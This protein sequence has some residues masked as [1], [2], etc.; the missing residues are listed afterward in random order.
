[1]SG[2][3]YAVILAGFLTVSIAY[4]IR[5]GYGMLLPEML[6]VLG[7]TKT[8]AGTI[9]GTYFV[10]YTIFT[11]VLG[12][13]SDLFNYRL[14]LT[15][16]AAI[17]GLGALL[18]ASVT[19]FVQACLFFG[20]AGLGHAACWAP[21]ASLVQKWV[22]NEKRGMMLSI[23]SIGIG[24]GVP[25]WGT[26][27]PVIVSAFDW[28]AGWMGMGL[29]AMAV[30]VMNLVLVRNPVGPDKP[31]TSTRQ[32]AEFVL[33]L[34]SALLKDKRFW[35][36]G[37]AYLLVGFNVL[38]PFSFLP[39]YARESLHLDYAASTRLISLI[40]FFGIAGQLT[41]G[42]LSD[43]KGRVHVLM[44]CGLIMGTACLGMVFFPSEWWLY[45]MTSFYGLAYGAVWPVYAATATDLFHSNQ[46]GSVV[47]LWTVF[48]GTGAIVS[49]IICGWTI[50]MTGSYTWAF[51]LGMASGLASTLCLTRI[52]IQAAQQA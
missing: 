29:F 46:T 13:L 49:P 8:Q 17:L 11:P 37:T 14:L 16:F 45:G 24:V 25:L 50:D 5:Y 48:L 26:F 20:L 1:M 33:G 10:M 31:M 18:M 27:L 42:T 3:A 47:G 15:L 34:Y 52:P 4:S 22:P 51:M 21:V 12:T 41:L 40:A 23:V 44:L 43:R 39:V 32:R 38:V 9:F 30:A 2:R 36:V 28:R 35:T 7:I 19:G 6:P